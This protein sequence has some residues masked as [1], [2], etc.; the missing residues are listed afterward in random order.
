MLFEQIVNGIALG[1]SY[2]LVAV[3]YSMVFGVLRLIN[4]AHGAVYTFGAFTVWFLCDKFAI[5]VP[6]AILISIV[7]TGFLGVVLNKI[8]LEPLRKKGEPGIP[9]LITTVG[10]S[11]VIINVLNIAFGAEIKRF[12]AIFNYGSFKIFGSTISWQQVII[13]LTC[14]VLLLILSFIVKKTKIGLGMRAVQQQATAASINGIN[15]NNIITFT[16][17]LGSA[18]AAI[19]GTLIASYY[20]YIRPSF[21]DATAMKAF[22]AAVLGGIGNLAGSMLGGLIVGV[23]ESLAVFSLGSTY[24]DIVS[25]SI[26]FAVL[27]IKPT[28]ILGKKVIKKV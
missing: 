28:G 24:I 2:A 20:Q 25:Y 19:A 14:I 6:L 16:F 27:L 3:G 17:F 26:I 22:S 1:A 7:M 18:S 12:P 21:A 4:F 13:A 5:P 9:A 23:I 11:Y 15:V 8:G 10:I